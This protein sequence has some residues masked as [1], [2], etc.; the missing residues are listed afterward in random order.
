[1]LVWQVLYHFSHVPSPFC[2]GY[3][4]DRVL[5]LCPGWSW[6]RSFYLCFLHSW[7]D[8]HEALCLTI[9][10]DGV[11]QTLCLGWS[12]TMI[13]LISAS[14]VAGIAGMS[15]WLS[16]ACLFLWY[17]SLSSGTYACW[18]GCLLL[19]LFCQSCFVLSIF[20]T[21]SRELFAWAGFKP[22][23]SWSL[24]FWSRWDCRHEPLVPDLHMPL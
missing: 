22:W 1:M 18:A 12:W 10:W 21:E 6:L 17:W 2:F 24:S 13:L 16:R 15:H 5:N 11:L 9:G 7:D 4:W 19:E 23:S 8:R 14:H 3:F 20:E